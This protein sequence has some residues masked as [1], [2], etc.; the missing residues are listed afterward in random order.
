MEVQLWRNAT[1]LLHIKSIKFLIDPMLGKKSSFGVFPWTQDNRPNPLVDLP[2]DTKEL[3]NYLASIDAVVVTH[4]HP[5][6]WDKATIERL[7]KN[8]PIICPIAIAETIANY[9][10]KN[11]KS[12][13]NNMVFKEISIALTQGKHGKGEIGKKMGTV[14]GFIFSTNEECIY[15]AGD[16]IWCEEVKMAINLH[17]PQYVVVAGGAATFAI[18]APVTMTS[19]D[20]MALCK[21]FPEIKVLV[22]HLEAI[23]PCIET[24]EY[25][26]KKVLENGFSNRCY[27]PKD[28][29]NLILH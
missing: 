22:T 17:N 21:I 29:K 13:E 23:S 15:F 5:D 14:N 20:I 7:D 19:E 6:H 26:S 3:D 25:I 27:I 10:F 1:V 18:G 4:L 24:R 8:L 16:T 11:I 9:G 28:G 2:F 12:F